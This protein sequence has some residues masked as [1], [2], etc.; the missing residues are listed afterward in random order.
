MDIQTRS[1][2]ILLHPTAL[3]GSPYCGDLGQGAIRYLDVLLKAGQTWW[4]MLPVNP[5]GSG[6]SPYATVSSFAGE[7]L[8]ISID[9][10]V[11]DGLL[12]PKELPPI[13]RHSVNKVAYGLA[14]AYKEPL[15]RLAYE[16]FR[17]QQRTFGGTKFRRFCKNQAFWLDN[18]ALFEVL[19]RR[20]Q[21]ADWTTWPSPIRRRQPTA[22]AKVAGES[23]Q[24]IQYEKFKQYLFDRQWRN[25][26]IQAKTRG[27]GLIGDLPI[28]VSHASADVWSH[29][30][31]FQL[32]KD[33]SMRAVAGVPPDAFSADGQLWGNALYNWKALRDTNYDWWCQRIGR[34]LQYFDCIRLDHFIGFERYWRIPATASSAKEGRWHKGPGHDFFRVLARHFPGLPL[35]AEDLGVVTIGV[36]RLRDAAQLPGMKVL[37]FAFGSKDGQSP[38]LPHNYPE[39]CVVY[40][41]THDNDTTVGWFKELK[42]AAA[43]NCHFSR[44]E[45]DNIS[46]YMSGEVNPI[47]WRM[48]EIAYQSKARIAII[49][50]QDILGL[51]SRARMNVPGV[52]HGNWLWRLDQLKLSANLSKRLAAL[53][54]N[55]GRLGAQGPLPK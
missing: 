27:I 53:S 24:E 17:S 2:G 43:N 50:C 16:R 40:T 51:G 26:K 39:N 52:G 10:L 33:G 41:G 4:Q 44:A 42:K 36:T 7:E 48:I 30:A 14:R 47:N 25:L 55:T 8:L 5:V 45:L 15:L 46:G 37:Q 34:L 13:K 38:Y 29:Q 19:R 21:T 32:Y 35:I 9:S 18:Y 6:E 22:L 20:Y 31:L 28:F 11:H 54:Q 1:A 49:P 3:P 12:L 23:D